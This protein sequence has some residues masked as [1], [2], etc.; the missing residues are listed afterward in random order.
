M[1]DSPQ[2]QFYKEV[3]RLLEEYPAEGPKEEQVTELRNQV[4]ELANQSEADDA[5]LSDLREQLTLIREKLQKVTGRKPEPDSEERPKGSEPADAGP[6]GPGMGGSEDPYV[7]SSDLVDDV[8]GG[9][10]FDSAIPNI[11]MSR[12]MGGRPWESGD[13]E[14]RAHSEDVVTAIK[15]ANSLRDE[16]AKL[17]EKY[18]DFDKFS[19]IDSHLK[20]IEVS[21]GTIKSEDDISFGDGVT[22][23]ELKKHK[24]QLEKIKNSLSALTVKA[25]QWQTKKKEKEEK[26]QER[27]T[28]RGPK[29]DWK[30]PSWLKPEDLSKTVKD[31]LG[32][33]DPKQWALIGAVLIVVT[34]AGGYLWYYLRKWKSPAS[35]QLRAWMKKTKKDNPG[36][37][38]GRP[39][40]K[41]AQVELAQIIVELNASDKK[42]LAK[43]LLKLQQ[44]AAQKE[45]Q[46]VDKL[47]DRVEQITG[48]AEQLEAAAVQL[49][50]DGDFE[51]AARVSNLIEMLDLN[52]SLEETPLPF[53][54]EAALMIECQELLAMDLSVRLG[55][56]ASGKAGILLKKIKKALTKS[57]EYLRTWVTKLRDAKTT[58]A[59]AEAKEKA[60]H[61]RETINNLKLKVK[62]FSHSDE[63][64][65]VQIDLPVIRET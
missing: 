42:K 13:K 22:V 54:A 34:V 19:A 11:D 45:S 27:E 28:T 64:K 47:M 12:M 24:R 5:D 40:P 17:K 36:W 30:W 23:K 56:A 61:W 35:K 9:S 44:D 10:P 18:P 2:A 59:K 29:K 48:N 51:R 1:S 8:P 52:A 26:E 55:G 20:K 3:T 15:L 58:K 39:V 31:Q 32:R 62:E 43:L 60:N 25:E 41:Q 57:I 14:E 37:R 49:I 6:S 21:L 65:K 7:P 33:L 46:K 38:P 63:A 16:V 4:I 50:A 53:D